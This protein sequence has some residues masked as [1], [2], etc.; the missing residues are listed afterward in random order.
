M[1][2]RFDI[3]ERIYFVLGVLII[4][5]FVVLYSSR[6]LLKTSMP[7]AINSLYFHEGRGWAIAANATVF[8]F[9]LAFLPYRR[10][11]AWRSKGAFSAFILA[12]MAEMFGIPL[13]LFIL[14]PILPAVVPD[15]TLRLSVYGWLGTGINLFGGLGLIVGTW[16][17]FLG[18]LLVIAG[19]KKIHA[20]NSLVDSGI[21]SRIR[22]PQY[23]GL[24]L[25]LTGWMIHWPT[26]LTLLMYPV[27]IFAYYRL[28]LKEEKD[29]LAEF[30]EPCRQYS[31][32]T[33]RFFPRIFSK[34]AL[35]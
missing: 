2:Q 33:P 17:T 14:S 25:I 28:A 3:Q 16:L 30:G 27:L 5:G 4:L 29:M 6:F 24:F 34:P 11:V 20:S 21:Y 23:S 31:Q 15:R 26:L 18:M 7:P 1:K 8:I 12:L 22:H 32:K 35:R 9:F 19:W 10:G 13:L